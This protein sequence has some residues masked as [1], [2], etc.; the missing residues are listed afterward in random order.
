M[1]IQARLDGNVNIVEQSSRELVKE[2]RIQ[3]ILYEKGHGRLSAK[4]AFL[5]CSEWRIILYPDSKV[6][7]ANM[8]PNWGRQDPGGPHVGHMNF[9][10]W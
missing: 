4:Y 9:V 6:H 2:A 7:G 10:I 1:G 8:G 5:V 3:R